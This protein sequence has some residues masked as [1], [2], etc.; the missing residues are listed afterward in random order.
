MTDRANDPECI[1]CRLVVIETD[2]MRILTIAAAA[3]PVLPRESIPA[4]ARVAEALNDAI[5]QRYGLRTI[6]TCP[7]AKSRET[8]YCAVHEI[9]ASMEALPRSFSFTALGEIA[10]SEFP[11]EDSRL[12]WQ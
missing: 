6:R 11:S 8:A 10:S 2:S 1:D 9:A 4:H 7:P 3:G 12:S 5:E